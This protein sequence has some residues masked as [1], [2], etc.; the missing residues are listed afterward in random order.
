MVNYFKL[1]E[2]R[3]VIWCKGMHICICVD[4]VTS[5]LLPRRK[6]LSC[7]YEQS[8][9]FTVY[10]WYLVHHK[11]WSGAWVQLDIGGWW[12]QK[13]PRKNKPQLTRSL[14]TC[15]LCDRSSTTWILNTCL[16]LLAAS[17]YYS[18]I[19]LWYSTRTCHVL[20]SLHSYSLS[21][22]L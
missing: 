11:R 3:I 2:I 7:L 8:L 15:W 1:N 16:I 20:L 6:K 5:Y 9:S 10:L 14:I 13:H 17:N 12:K 21:F 4:I 18:S 19:D 22:K